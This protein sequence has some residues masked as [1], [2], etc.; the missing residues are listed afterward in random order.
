MKLGEQNYYVNK[1]IIKKAELA[2]CNVFIQEGGYALNSSSEKD[3]SRLSKVTDPP[4]QPNNHST[5]CKIKPR[6]EFL[7]QKT[8][9]G[10]SNQG[11]V[12]K[13]E[14]HDRKI[15]EASGGEAGHSSALLQERPYAQ[16]QTDEGTEDLV[17]KE[18]SDENFLVYDQ[19]ES[20]QNKQRYPRG[21]QSLKRPELLK[22]SITCS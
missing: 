9:P 13:T 16:L 5:S 11:F 8:T 17:L 7:T 1:L 18:A 3:F 15:T 2:N 4:E 22:K 10:C 14:Q 19:V 6:H 20:R 12:D 21:A